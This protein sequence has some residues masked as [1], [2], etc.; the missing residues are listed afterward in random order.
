M[1][2]NKQKDK[3]NNK[4]KIISIVLIVI[5][6][7]FIISGGLYIFLDKNFSFVL[8]GEE[9]VELGVNKKYLESGA[10][11]KFFGKKIDNIKITNNIDNTKVGEYK[12]NYSSKVLFITKRLQ[13]KVIV[14][15]LEKP[16]IELNGEKDVYLNLGEEYQ[17][18]G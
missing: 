5:S 8:I 16:H 12:V 14:K 11:S 7:F 6:L 18:A 9:E 10:V 13:R 3:S 15:D 17:E 2:K 4:F 1:K